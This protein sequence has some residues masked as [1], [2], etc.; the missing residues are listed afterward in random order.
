M[1]LTRNHAYAVIPEEY[2]AYMMDTETDPCWTDR[3]LVLFNVYMTC[4]WNKTSRQQQ[5]YKWCSWHGTEHY[6]T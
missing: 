3:Q 6:S 1:E 5:H 2:F 4:L